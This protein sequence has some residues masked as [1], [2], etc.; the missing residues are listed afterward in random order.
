MTM[1]EDTA[2]RIAV[3]LEALVTEARIANLLV[4]GTTATVPET[5]QV[6]TRSAALTLLKVDPRV[7]DAVVPPKPGKK[8][9]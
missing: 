4:A 2:V 6:D 1:T 5:E 3:A 9:G 8:G 7:G